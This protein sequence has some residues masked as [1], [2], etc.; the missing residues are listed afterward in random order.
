M[1]SLPINNQLA[2]EINQIPNAF[3]NGALNINAIDQAIQSLPGVRLDELKLV[4]LMFCSC[5]C[6]GVYLFC[7]K[8]GVLQN[9]IIPSKVFNNVGPKSDVV[10]IGKTSSR[11]FVERI[12]AHFAPRS[13][14]FMN[15]VMKRITEITKGAITDKNICDS[16]GIATKLYLK[17]I[18]F[19]KC[20][21]VAPFTEEDMEVDLINYYLPS[22]NKIPGMRNK[23]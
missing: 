17:L 12:A 14:D 5:H 20:D 21:D 23:K 3:S 9:Q 15:M 2:V 22:L 19:D 1:S 18:I 10:Y 6:N 13:W 4:D 8:D 11:S 7:D 16:Y